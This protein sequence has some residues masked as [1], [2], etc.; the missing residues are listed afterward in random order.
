MTGKEVEE[1]VRYLRARSGY[2]DYEH[3]FEDDGRIIG[4]DDTSDSWVVT[5][6]D[7][8]SGWFYEW[9][10]PANVYPQQLGDLWLDACATWRQMLAEK[11]AP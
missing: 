4:R 8:A 3:V 2:I 5:F 11:E 7:R 9:L 1:S 10:I 6:R